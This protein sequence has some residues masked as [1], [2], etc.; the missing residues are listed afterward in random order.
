MAEDERGAA[1]NEVPATS[2][3]AMAGDGDAD[4]VARAREILLA[5][6]FPIERIR[7]LPASGGGDAVPGVTLYERRTVFLAC[8]ALLEDGA[9]H[10]A[11]ELARLLQGQLPG[12]TRKDV[13]S[14]LSGD[15]KDRVAYDRETYT[16]R[17]RRPGEGEA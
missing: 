4:L 8:C 5:E 17:L 12:V 14:A 3:A 15:S 16:Y 7:I 11:K 6:G 10:A 13:N 1:G 9:P 2:R